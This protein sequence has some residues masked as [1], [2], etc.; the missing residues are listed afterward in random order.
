MN[1]SYQWLKAIAPSLELTPDEVAERLAL[2]GAPVEETEDLGAPFADLVVGRV[3][4]S[5]R[6]P[7][8][9]RLSLCQVD[10]GGDEILQVI[11]GAPNV[12]EGGFYP[13]APVGSVLPGGLKIKKA[14]IRGVHS[15]GMLCSERELGL[16][17]NHEGILELHGDLTPGQPLV[18]ALAMDDVRMDI[19]VSPNRGDLLS[20]LGVARELAPEGH[21]GLVIPPIP[22]G[23]SYDA[24][25]KVDA[26]QVD[27]AGFTLRIEDP[28]LCYRFLAVVIRGVTVGPS[29]DWLANRLRS[30]GAQ[31]INNVVDATNYVMLELGHPMHA[32]DLERLNGSTLVAR[33]AREGETLVTLDGVERELT[34]DMMTI[35][36]AKV[37][38]GIGGVMGG[39]DSEVTDGTTQVLLEAALFDPP[40]IRATRRTLDMS[41][42]AS[43]RFE[44][45]VDPALHE[46]A[47]RHAAELI[48]AIA[49]GEADG[50][51]LD[52]DTRS[53][54][55]EVVTLRPARA[56]HVLGVEFDARACTELLEPLGFEVDAGDPELL[57]VTVPGFRSYDV[58]REVDLIE[59]V[60]RTYG[61]DAFPDDL[62]S[63]RPGTVPDHPL[64]QLEDRLRSVLVGW[65]ML[66]CHTPAFGPTSE[67][68]VELNNPIS[69]NDTHM[70]RSI[71]PAL[72]R[73]VGYNFSRGTRTVRLFELG[74]SFRSGQDGGPPRE[75]PHLAVAFTG[76]RAPSHWSGPE[77]ETDIW[78]LKALAESLV[79]ATY[80]GGSTAPSS[81][82]HPL[83]APGATLELRAGDGSR[84][85]WAGGLRSGM[86]DA[87]A[88][89]GPVFGLELT[90]PDEPVESEAVLAEA[91]PAFPGVDRDLALLAPSGVSAAEM[92]DT[93]AS[94]AG[95]LLAD[96]SVFDQYEGEGLP[97]G[98]R[99]VAFRLRF[100][101]PE[102]TLTDREVERATD[103]VLRKLKE[104][105]GV[106]AR[107]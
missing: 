33:R 94:A 85:G 81:H 31:P 96:V 78:D 8:A 64:F 84:V 43:Y 36:D 91:L 68:E 35:C 23:R 19:E 93:I 46:R 92:R 71:L 99:S 16:G 54:T 15:V 9:D 57:A 34:P 98:V 14:K 104:E 39:G 56:T 21:A 26:R 88:W 4:T 45:G 55:P 66:E 61:Y 75:A 3:V 83:L 105:L 29:P 76:S 100:Q 12:K 50:E 47:I 70:R 87:P 28:D 74:T 44:R 5:G 52:V 103:R 63:F 11:C 24:P 18:G 42:D 65:G 60:A 40:S 48:M 89:A 17:R 37:P 67:G 69:Q 1:V 101:S 86:V 20:H 79:E 22:G 13:F 7:D 30:V 82:E 2:R 27:S 53:W 97:D 77:Q 38:V 106:E 6:H 102:R 80:P 59:E 51:L 90:L 41:T 32:Y 58:T 107:G 73:R 25:T 49:G 95:R 72:S 10:A 62:E